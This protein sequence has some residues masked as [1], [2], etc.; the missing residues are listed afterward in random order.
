M[1]DFIKGN[2]F[3][4]ILPCHL[5]RLFCKSGARREDERIHAKPLMLSLHLLDPPNVSLPRGIAAFEADVHRS[6]AV[7]ALAR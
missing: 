3:Y 4:S 7:L 5:L 1:V 6:A 2:G